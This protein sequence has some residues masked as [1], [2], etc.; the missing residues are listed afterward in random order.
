MLPV[1]LLG[2]VLRVA[3]RRGNQEQPAQRQGAD[4]YQP[5]RNG[6]DAGKPEVAAPGP[7]G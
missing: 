1:Q 6:H 4:Q 5:E 2:A 7:A 3:D